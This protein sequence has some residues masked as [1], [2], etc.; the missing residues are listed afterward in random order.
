MERTELVEKI[1]EF[2]GEREDVDTLD[3]VITELNGV[4]NKV[5]TVNKE[6][7]EK[8]IKR[9]S[10]NVEEEKEK[11]KEEDEPKNVTI[12]DLFTEKEGK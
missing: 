7:R 5:D 1:T 6:W 11:E 10:G 12:D 2:F 8:Y 9:F 4:Y 3:A